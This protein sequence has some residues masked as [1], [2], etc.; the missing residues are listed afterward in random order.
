MK[1]IF[2]ALGIFGYIIYLGIGVVQ[3]A[4]IYAFLE[5]YCGWNFLISLIF[6]FFIAYIPIL[7]S[8]CG[9]FGAVEVWNWEIWQA[10]ILFCWPI[11]IILL[12]TITSAVLCITSIFLNKKQNNNVQLLQEK[13]IIDITPE[14]NE[15]INIISKKSKSFL[16]KLRYG[17]YSLVKTFWCFGV[18]VF[19]AF[20][21]VSKIL[22]TQ[23]F[24]SFIFR[25][26][27]RSGFIIIYIFYISIIYI[28]API[29]YIG[30]W[31]SATKYT[32]RKIWVILTKAVV[33]W[34]LVMYIISFVNLIPIVLKIFS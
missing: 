2:G 15:E 21:L 1:N 4:A 17:E 7:G 6:G 14:N 5:D 30:T 8:I 9:A 27:G 12:P 34:W 20:G 22:I 28:Y 23:D 26:F 16:T 31:R 29:L 19:I 3:L 10:I 25:E 13:E 24:M 33:C 11:L 32:G 18:I